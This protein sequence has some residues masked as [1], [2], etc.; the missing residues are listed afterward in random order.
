MVELIHGTS[1]N[2]MWVAEDRVQEYLAAG[3]KLAAKPVSEKPAEEK[4]KLA[5]RQRRK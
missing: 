5:P 4:K 1:G 3:H 2:P